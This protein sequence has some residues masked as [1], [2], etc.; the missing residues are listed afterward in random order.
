MS[1]PLYITL[2]IQNHEEEIDTTTKEEKDTGFR[3]KYSKLQEW[4]AW[5]NAEPIDEKREMLRRILC[6]NNPEAV[7]ELARLA[8]ME[9]EP[10]LIKHSEKKCET[11]NLRE[12]RESNSTDMPRDLKLEDK[13][14]EKDY[15]STANDRK[16]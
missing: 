7:D 12:L 9:P 1:I 15:Q 10:L 14:I 2:R 6:T 5:S 13:A 11:V 4:K 8:S 16:D 3:Q